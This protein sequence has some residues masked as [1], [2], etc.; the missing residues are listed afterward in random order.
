MD[1]ESMSTVQTVLNG[2]AAKFRATLTDGQRLIVERHLAEAVK[3]DKGER[4]LADAYRATG[5]A[6]GFL[7]YQTSRAT[8]PSDPRHDAWRR[9]ILASAELELN[10]HGWM[11][12]HGFIGVEDVGSQTSSRVRQVGPDVV[13]EFQGV[14]PE[15]GAWFWPSEEPH[16]RLYVGRR[17]RTGPR[18]VTETD[19]LRQ[20]WASAEAIDDTFP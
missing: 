9:F 10:Q 20:E 3:W 16:R 1:G 4:S 11:T 13:I 19:R 2:M 7:R 12:K 18:R 17:I 14:D 15:D 6:S 8:G 5:G